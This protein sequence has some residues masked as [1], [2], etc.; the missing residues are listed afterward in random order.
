METTRT[1]P[2]TLEVAFGPYA[3]G[4]VLHPMGSDKFKMP[5]RKASPMLGVYLAA[6]AICGV[7]AAIVVVCK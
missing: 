6:L 7:A 1:H 3:R 4:S 2:R 5:R